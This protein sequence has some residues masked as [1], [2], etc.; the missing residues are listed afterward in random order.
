MGLFDSFTDIFSSDSNG[1][2]LSTLLDAGSSAL[3]GSNDGGQF[4]PISYGGYNVP[5][6]PSYPIGQPTMASVPMVARAAASGIA[7]WSA[8]FPSLWQA[9]QRFRGNGVP[10][11]VEKLYSALKRFGPSAM[12]GIIGAAAL[13]DL[14]TYKAT[15]KRRRMNVANTKALRKSLRRLQGF[16]N[17]SHKVSAQLSRACR[18]R[19]P[20]ATRH[21]SRKC[22]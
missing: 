21:V 8:Q 7:R 4:L 10:M 15:H 6:M 16:E 3:G 22:K 18:T 5:Q 2:F 14:I 13:N 17:L 11:T 20:R 12:T 19:S 9:V 1:G